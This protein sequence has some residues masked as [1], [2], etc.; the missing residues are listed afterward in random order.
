MKGYGTPILSE[1]QYQ[2][3]GKELNADFGLDLYDYGAR[4]Y[5]ASIGRWHGVDPL[6]EAFIV[7]SPY[8]YGVNNPIMMVDPD[9]RA[10]RHCDSCI[11]GDGGDKPK[12]IAHD[13][14]ETKKIVR[15]LRF[16]NKS[17]RR[18]FRKLKKEAK[19]NGRQVVFNRTKSGGEL[20]EIVENGELEATPDGGEDKQ[21]GR[22]QQDWANFSHVDEDKDDA[23]IGKVEFQEDFSLDLLLNNR[24]NSQGE[25]TR[26]LSSSFSKE[27][28]DRWEINVITPSEINGQY[29]NRNVRIEN[30]NSPS[31]NVTLEGQIPNYF[32]YLHIEASVTAISKPRIVKVYERRLFGIRIGYRWNTANYNYKLKEGENA[33]DFTKTI[34][35]PELYQQ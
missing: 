18:A 31:T 34:G 27:N 1:N 23:A 8:N 6:A 2:Y 9:G 10:S 29:I 11:D 16:R 14:K 13:N 22:M 28:F 30:P 17:F 7:H 20:T 24:G 12:P 3:N 4:W 25:Q 5:D 33:N 19:K 32:D 26:F 35:T 21:R 15:K